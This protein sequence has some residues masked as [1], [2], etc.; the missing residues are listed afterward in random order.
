ML[1]LEYHRGGTGLVA[2]VDLF[3]VAVEGKILRDT[4]LV[5]GCEDG[6]LLLR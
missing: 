2:V 5:E 6:L 1:V 4:S 3:L